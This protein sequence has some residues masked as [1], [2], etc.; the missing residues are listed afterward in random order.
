MA[1]AGAE[2]AQKILRAINGETGITVPTYVNLASDPVGGKALKQEL[3][4]DLEYFSSI[5]ELG[6]SPAP[7]CVDDT[8]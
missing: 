7:S 8:I 4:E 3:G 5:V 1:Y 2:F 6:V